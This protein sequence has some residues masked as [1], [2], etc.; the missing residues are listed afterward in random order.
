MKNKICL[1]VS[2]GCAGVCFVL[3]LLQHLFIIDGSGYFMY[4]KPLSG[5]LIPALYVV[6]AIALVFGAA[7]FLFG[8]K[9]AID[10][11]V[12][13]SAGSLSVLYIVAAAL[14]MVHSGICFVTSDKAPEILVRLLAVGGLVS[15]IYFAILGVGTLKNKLPSALHFFGLFP[16]LYICLFGVCEFYKSFEYV[17]KSEISILTLSVCALMAFITSV[18]LSTAGVPVT[19]KR[20]AAITVLYPVF[21]MSTAPFF[22][23]TDG[24]PGTKIFAII[25][26]LFVLIAYIVLGRINYVKPQYNYTADNSPSAALDIYMDDIPEE[27]ED[28]DE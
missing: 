2:F 7:V 16:P 3:R 24:N 9:T 6:F 19:K 23:I 28:T 13:Q 12:I 27:K 15:G 10:S 17:K 18:T 5:L 14:I 22:M 4:D 21:A 8:Q 11:G 1:A 26:L 25:Q 20:M